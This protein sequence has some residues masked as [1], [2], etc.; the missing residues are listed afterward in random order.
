MKLDYRFISRNAQMVEV[1]NRADKLT[2][3]ARLAHW[4]RLW[5]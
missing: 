4:L 5:R 3:R 2:W 1:L